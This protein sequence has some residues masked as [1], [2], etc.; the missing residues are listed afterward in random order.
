[1]EPRTRVPTRRRRRCGRRRASTRRQA[2]RQ[3]PDGRRRGRRRCASEPDAMAW[4]GLFRPERGAA[5][6]RRRGVRP[7]RARGRGRDRRPPAA[8]AGALRRHAVRRAARGDA[9]WT[10]SRRSSSARSTSSSGRTSCSPS[11]TAGRPTW[12]PS[13]SAWRATRSCSRAGPEAVLYAILDRVVDGY[14]P[15]VAGLQKDIDEIEIQVFSG[16]PQGVPAHL[17]AVAAR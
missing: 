6:A 1:M 16:D 13:G 9:T 8:E 3:P 5:A 7:A 15:V 4:I 14:A 10:T 2:D 17:R 12:P 11:A